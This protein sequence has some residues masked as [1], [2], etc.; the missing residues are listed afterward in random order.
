[1]LQQSSQAST[2]VR[3]PTNQPTQTP[4]APSDPA[5]A[6]LD[7]PTYQAFLHELRQAEQKYGLRMQEAMKLP[8]SERFDM[9][10]KLKNSWNTKQST[11][12]KKYGIRLRDRRS[13]E[14]I[15]AERVRLLGTPDGATEW[16][17]HE[18][19]GKRPRIEG[20]TSSARASPAQAPA[21]TNPDTPRKRVALSEMGGLSGSVGSAETTD[22]TAFL[23][24]S[25]PRGMAQLHQLQPQQQPNNSGTSHN[26]PMVLDG[27]SEAQSNQQSRQQSQTA[28]SNDDSDGDSVDSS[29]DGDEDIPNH[30]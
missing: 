25:Q 5:Y 20:S 23:T 6:H 27:D 19:A 30:R 22:P 11:T 15:E 14:E 17:E 29:T 7:A 8:E 1:M 28:A 9:L 4:G 16:M 21:P 12:R 3:P 26:D 2:P 18:R 24:S 13:K 10:S